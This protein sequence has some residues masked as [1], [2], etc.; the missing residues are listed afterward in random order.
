MRWRSAKAPS[1]DVTP[2]FLRLRSGRRRPPGPCR[3]RPVRQ[4]PRPGSDRDHPAGCIYPA[5]GICSAAASG[6]GLCAAVCGPP[7]SSASSAG[8]YAEATDPQLSPET[9][10]G[11]PREASGPRLHYKASPEASSTG[12]YHKASPARRYFKASSGR[13]FNGMEGNED[14]PGQQAALSVHQAGNVLVRIGWQASHLLPQPATKTLHRYHVCP[15]NQVHS[16]GSA[17]VR[18]MIQDDG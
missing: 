1:R 3:S 10:A 2:I 14:Q 7:R 12:R 16:M 13:G 8:A 4:T 9:S 11:A 6:T 18:A 5:S 15:K 17:G